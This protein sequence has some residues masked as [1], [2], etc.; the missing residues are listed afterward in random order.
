MFPHD[1]GRVIPGRGDV[2]ECEGESACS[3][4]GGDRRERERERRRR[5]GGMDNIGYELI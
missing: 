2:E 4:G 3:V 5:S 1:D